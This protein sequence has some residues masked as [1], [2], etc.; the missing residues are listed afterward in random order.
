MKNITKLTTTLAAAAALTLSFSA[1]ADSSC[2]STLLLTNIQEHV[3]LEKQTLV[4]NKL[5]NSKYFSGNISLNRNRIMIFPN[6]GSPIIGTVKMI[7]CNNHSISILTSLS[8]KAF[9][10]TYKLLPPI[11]SS[12]TIRPGTEWKIAPTPVAQGAPIM[13]QM[14]ITKIG[15]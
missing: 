8:A 14:V 2:P 9:T 1:F 10:A 4:N 15:N 6:S 13:N 7:K 11:N 5:T 3:S 12:L